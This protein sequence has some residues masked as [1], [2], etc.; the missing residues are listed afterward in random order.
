MMTALTSRHCTV[1][2]ILQDIEQDSDT[3]H[4]E[5]RCEERNKDRRLEVQLEKDGDDSTRWNRMK[6]NALYTDSDKTA[7]KCD[8]LALQLIHLCVM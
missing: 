4:L 1:Q 3:G 7:V 2:W 8:I 5:Q 6:T